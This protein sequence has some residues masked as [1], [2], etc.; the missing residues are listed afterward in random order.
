MSQLI[1]ISAVA[2]IDC[3]SLDTAELPA[4]GGVGMILK[5]I[6][7]A[8]YVKSLTPDGPAN[9]CGKIKVNDVLVAVNGRDIKSLKIT[10]VKFYAMICCYLITN[11]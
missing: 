8:L 11:H 7:Q 4:K 10:E 6:D 1:M 9:A 2:V 3:A 5:E